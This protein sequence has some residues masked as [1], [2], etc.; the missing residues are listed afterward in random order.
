MDAK[1]RFVA[2]V[3]QPGIW[4]STAMV[5]SNRSRRGRD[6]RCQGMTGPKPKTLGSAFGL[7]VCLSDPYPAHVA[8]DDLDAF[9]VSA[10]DLE[11][12]V[13]ASGPAGGLVADRVVTIEGDT[14]AGAALEDLESVDI[15][16]VAA[17]GLAVNH[18]EGVTP[19]PEG[20]CR[21]IGRGQGTDGD[22]R[23]SGDC[24]IAGQGQSGLQSHDLRGY[25]VTCRHGLEAGYGPG[26]QDGEHGDGH[27]QLDQG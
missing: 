14:G 22:G 7:V 10:T 6:D 20:A 23:S 21:V 18:D 2:E 19:V 3:A 17:G 5:L 4:L 24:G 9:P 26:H 1:R 25:F 11:S 8:D 12:P 16:Q 15:G 13:V 27:D